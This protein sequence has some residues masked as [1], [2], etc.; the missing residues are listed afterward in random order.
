MSGTTLVR[1]DLVCAQVVPVSR[2]SCLNTLN[3]LNISVLEPII[4]D[5]VQIGSHKT[6][7]CG[8]SF[9]YAEKMET[10]EERMEDFMD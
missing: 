6:E 2:T 7:S 4:E 10:Q 9:F 3:K 5:G 8:F 1:Y